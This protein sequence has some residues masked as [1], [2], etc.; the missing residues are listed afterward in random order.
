K[1]D[2]RRSL[3]AAWLLAP[4]ALGAWINAR[5]WTRRR[6]Q[7]DAI[8]GDVWLGRLPNTVDMHGGPF[9]ALC[10]LCAELPAPRGPWAYAG[11]A[12]LD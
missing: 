11:H 12:W 3:A 8:T 5:L 6:P 4:H 10:D 7:P 2:G 1:H 9:A